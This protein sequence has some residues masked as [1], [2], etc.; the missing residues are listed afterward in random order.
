MSEP[1]WASEKPFAGPDDPVTSTCWDCGAT[2]RRGESGHHSCVAH[3]KTHALRLAEEVERLKAECRVE[4]ERANGTR[5]ASDNALT[6]I[7]ADILK[8]VAD[9][10]AR[11]RRGLL[12]WWNDGKLSHE[13]LPLAIDRIVPGEG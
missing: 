8:A 1:D 5:I 13:A 10:R 7:N 11:I 12:A 9:E 2:W 6:R 4:R 3:L